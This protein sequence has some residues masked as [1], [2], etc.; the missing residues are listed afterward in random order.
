MT[1]RLTFL[2][3]AVGALVVTA[4]VSAPASSEELTFQSNGYMLHGC[5]T[6][7]QRDGSFPVVIYNHGSDKNPGPCGP[8]EL[9]RAYVE[10][11]Y[12]FF[13]FHRHGHG[14]SP[15]DY[16][17]DLQKGIAAGVRDP[18]VRAQRIAALHDIYNFDVAG[19]RK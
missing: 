13:S 11:G 14:Q 19:D 1:V 8:P 9:V 16:I 18:P 12:L 17:L 4:S 5:I 6:R 7:P 3:V 10:H 2:A 15:G